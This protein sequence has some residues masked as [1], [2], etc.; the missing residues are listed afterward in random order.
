MALHWPHVPE[1][2]GCPIRTRDDTRRVYDALKDATS[3][4]VEIQREDQEYVVVLDATSG[5]SEIADLPGFEEALR[6]N[7]ATSPHHVARPGVEDAGEERDRPGLSRAAVH[8]SLGYGL[9]ASSILRTCCVC[10]PGLAHPKMD[11]TY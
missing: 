7:R 11:K 10:P 5:S 9:G 6:L 3:L 2:T 8:Y 4:I 1:S